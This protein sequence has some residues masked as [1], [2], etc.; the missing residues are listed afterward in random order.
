MSLS[1]VHRY[2]PS[3]VPN[4]CRDESRAKL[5]ASLQN[6][7]RL[8]AIGVAPCQ[9]AVGQKTATGRPT[10]RRRELEGYEHNILYRFASRR[11]AS[12][13]DDGVR[14]NYQKLDA[15]LKQV[16]RAGD[17]RMRNGKISLRARYGDA[18]QAR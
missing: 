16:L 1:R 18:R 5:T 15:A 14:V 17:I 7:E 9:Q 12:D 8:A 2:R 10:R 6:Q 13:L 3:T 4:E 11:F